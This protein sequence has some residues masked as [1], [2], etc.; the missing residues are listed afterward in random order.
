M[1]DL[2]ICLCEGKKCDLKDTCL[3]YIYHLKSSEGDYNTYF[4]ESPIFNNKCDFYIK[5]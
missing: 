4:E 5:Y 1:F 2:D 3:R